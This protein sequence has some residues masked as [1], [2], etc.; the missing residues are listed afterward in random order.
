MKKITCRQYFEYEPN[1]RASEQQ[2]KATR[3]A[4]SRQAYTTRQP[5]ATV[6]TQP[7]RPPTT[8]PLHSDFQISVFGKW[9][10]LVHRVISGGFTE[11]FDVRLS[12]P[13]KPA[14]AQ[15]FFFAME[16]KSTVPL[17]AH[18]IQKATK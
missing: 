18:I 13:L 8:Q 12:T 17:L 15:H 3:S 10:V 16:K 11:C 5:A 2:P 1:Y 6:R 7:T 4:H 9:K 14:A